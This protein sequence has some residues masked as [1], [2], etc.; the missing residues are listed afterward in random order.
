[1][2]GEEKLIIIEKY[3]EFL[4]YIYPVIQ[5][6]P[7]KHGVLRENFIKVLFEQVEILYKAVKTTQKS[8]LYEADANIA[9]IKF[10]LRFLSHKDRKLISKKQS[11]V[12]NIKLV[13]V[14]KILNSWINK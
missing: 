5:G 8:K 9:N 13:E 10:Y 4:N 6:V 12:S 11:E 2:R 14:G 3:E 1:M 7:R